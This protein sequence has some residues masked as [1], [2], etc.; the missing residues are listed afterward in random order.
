M[1]LDSRDKQPFARFLGT[2]KK[3]KEDCCI[4][5]SKSMSGWFPHIIVELEYVTP[6]FNPN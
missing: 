1:D 6:C 4:G 2:V 5:K 3:P